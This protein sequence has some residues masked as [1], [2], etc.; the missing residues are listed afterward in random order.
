MLSV[1]RYHRISDSTHLILCAL[2]IEKLAL[3]EDICSSTPSQA[4]LNLGYIGT[5]DTMRAVAADAQAQNV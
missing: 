1:H 3:V 2:S 4:V 5:V